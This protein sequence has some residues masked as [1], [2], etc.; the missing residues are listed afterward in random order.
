MT[1]DDNGRIYALT[2]PCPRLVV[3]ILQPNSLWTVKTYFLGGTVNGM[4]HA[5]KN[6]NRFL[7][8]IDDASMILSIQELKREDDNSAKIVRTSAIALPLV[9]I[10]VLVDP[11]PP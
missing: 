10:P 1:C 3:M 4:C 5:N 7:M 9:P 2:H 6:N 11:M 8:R